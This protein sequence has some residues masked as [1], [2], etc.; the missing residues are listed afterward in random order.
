MKMMIM[1][2]EKGRMIECMTGK[3]NES[4]VYFHNCCEIDRLGQHI[5]FT[6]KYVE[7][8]MFFALPLYS[9]QLISA[10]LAL[11]AH[12]SAFSFALQLN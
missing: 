12:L 9:F 1:E 10:D 8:F 6:K 2:S 5:K 3:S 7:S 4:L 11:L